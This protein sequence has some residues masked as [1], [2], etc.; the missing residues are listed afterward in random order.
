MHLQQLLALRIPDVEH[1]VSDRDAILYALGVGAGEH[2]TDAA[3]LRH[4][5]EPGLRLMPAMVNVIA[6][7]AGWTQDPALGIDYGRLVHG[8]QSFELHTPLRRATIY[9]G[10]TRIVDVVDKGV[11][12]GAM[13]FI[14]K[15][16]YDQASAQ[17]VATVRSTYVL[18]GD[19][20][21]GGTT[22]RVPSRPAPPQGAPD[23]R[24][25]SP[26]R[27]DAA[28]LYRLSGDDNPLHASPEV[29]QRA[30]FP[31]PILHGLCTMGIAAHA[32]TEHCCEGT[33]ERLLSMDVR[34]SAPVYPGEHLETLVWR[35]DRDC[36][37]FSV[38]AIEREA[39]V[40]SHGIARIMR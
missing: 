36:L 27:R 28:L 20:G 38:R 22:T 23:A 21:C 9:L 12:K 16:L 6:H 39:T 7:P 26:T 4:C 13:L 24:F 35:A 15:E 40:L 34:F 37:Q 1:A 17:R 14:E 33:P 2:G 31:R 29:A 8:E 3:A 19:G 11:D 32:L 25:V 10:R 30:G 5:Y 18:R